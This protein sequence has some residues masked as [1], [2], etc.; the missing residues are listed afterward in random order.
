MYSFMS[1]LLLLTLGQQNS[2]MLQVAM[3]VHFHCYTLFY[4]ITHHNLFICSRT[5]G[6]WLFPIFNYCKQGCDE[7]L[8]MVLCK[9]FFKLYLQDVI[10]GSPRVHI[11]YLHDSIKL[12]FQRGFTD[13]YSYQLS[14]F[15]NH[16][17]VI[18][19]L[20]EKTMNKTNKIPVLITFTFQWMVTY[21]KQ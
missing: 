18:Q 2:S 8:Y 3:A 20:R 12:F 15:I 11:S 13:L 19:V 4:C 17:C 5:D 10:D 21:K 14:I 7:H 1:L 6:I 16:Y 9:T